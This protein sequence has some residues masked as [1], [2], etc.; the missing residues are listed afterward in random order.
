MLHRIIFITACA[1][2][3]L[4]QHKRMRWTLTRLIN[5]TFNNAR[6]RAAH[7]LL[8][9]SFSSST[10]DLKMN[11]IKI[12]MIN[13]KYVKTFSMILWCQWFSGPT[14]VLFSIN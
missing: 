2:N 6:P 5:S 14:H 8:M 4:L 12:N 3:G 1:L 7:S 9:S 13:V 11:T 10:C